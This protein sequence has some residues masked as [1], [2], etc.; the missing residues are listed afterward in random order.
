MPDEFF[1]KMEQNG[2]SEK[3]HRIPYVPKYACCYCTSLIVIQLGH[4]PLRQTEDLR[5]TQRIFSRF[6]CIHI[7]PP[8]N[9]LAG[10]ARRNGGEHVARRHY[11]H[12]ILTI[13][14]KQ[15]PKPLAVPHRFP[16]DFTEK[17]SSGSTELY[18]VSSYPRPSPYIACLRVPRLLPRECL[19][20]ILYCCD[21][22]VGATTVLVG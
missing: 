18:I 5:R 3:S 8:P 20:M 15:R 6:E 11:T 7:A 21:N 17:K 19:K 12:V 2:G 14:A 16:D 10:D 22:Q 1:A 13:L 9:V 4:I